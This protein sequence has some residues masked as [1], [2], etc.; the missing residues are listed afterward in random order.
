M[1]PAAVS[2]ELGSVTELP[3]LMAVPSGLWP[4]AG[5]PVIDAVGATLFTVRVKVA[6]AVRP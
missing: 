2:A 5:A 1:K 6:V 3:R 4:D